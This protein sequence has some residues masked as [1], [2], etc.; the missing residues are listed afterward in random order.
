MCTYVDFALLCFD[1]VSLP[2][3]VDDGISCTEVQYIITL[4]HKCSHRY[5]Y[6]YYNIYGPLDCVW[7]Y[8][9]EPVPER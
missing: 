9:G 7:D 3:L 2:Y 1:S 4:L 8:L 5:Y 6:D